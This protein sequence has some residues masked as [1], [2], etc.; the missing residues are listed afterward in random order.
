MKYLKIIKHLIAIHP[1]RSL[2]LFSFIILF[3]VILF[4]YRKIAINRITNYYSQFKN[5]R[6]IRY[7]IVLSTLFTSIIIVFFYF[8]RIKK[9][10]YKSENISISN[11]NHLFGIDI[12][13][14]NG[15]INWNEVTKSKHP[16]K[17]IFIKATEG[18]KLVDRRFHNNWEK[19]TENGYI[20]GAY[21]FYKPDVNSTNQFKLF[22]STVKLNKGDLLPVLDVEESSKLGRDNLIKGIRNWINLCKKKYGVKPIL[23]TGRKFYTKFLSDE[24]LDC[25]LWIASYSN[26][27]S[28]SELEW[29]L[30]QFT[31]KVIVKGI[32]ENVD[33]NNFKGDLIKLKNDYCIK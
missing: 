7:G 14:H 19:A 11:T 30:H 4:Y 21:H 1:I 12:S 26:E 10:H 9:N 23:Y 18:Q 25:P 27:E 28:I 32:P 22:C 31:E 17:Y 5:N 15:V 13:H 20:K 6:K 16:I 8:T 29:D 2:L 3:F 33:G 24:F